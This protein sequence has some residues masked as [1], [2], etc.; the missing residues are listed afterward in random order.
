MARIP[1]PEVSDREPDEAMS[2]DDWAREQIRLTAA[3]QGIGVD[4][5]EDEEDDEDEEDRFAP[6]EVSTYPG[7]AAE[8]IS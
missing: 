3:L 4:G 8:A 6:P 1:T 7:K 5:E 2:R